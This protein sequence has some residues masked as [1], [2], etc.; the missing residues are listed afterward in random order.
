M[1]SLIPSSRELSKRMAQH[2]F[3]KEGH[4]VIELGGGTG[5]LTRSLLQHVSA[6][7]FCVI[8]KDLKLVKHLRT[9]FPH[10]LIIHGDATHL[11]SLIPNSFSNK[12][13]TII[14]G[15]PLLTLPMDTQKKIIE[16]SLKVL[17]PEG[18][19]LQFTYSPFSSLPAHKYGLS[20]TRKGVVLSNFP[21]ASIWSYE[22]LSPL[23]TD[24]A[25]SR[26]SIN[27]T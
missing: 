9:L 7:N 23:N 21:P 11:S 16:E 25:I 15:L 27:I 19:I 13:T 5:A 8:E 6:E 12:V 3:L 10:I 17:V 2:L 22:R 24:S 26:D 18:R 20:K 14:S 1:G 4:F